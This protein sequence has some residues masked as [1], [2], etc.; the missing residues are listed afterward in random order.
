MR[1]VV[2]ALVAAVFSAA[3][4]AGSRPAVAGVPEG[5]PS[6][7]SGTT[8]DTVSGQAQGCLPGALGA[9]NLVGRAHDLAL[10]LLQRMMFLHIP[11]T[12]G[13]SVEDMIPD[14]STRKVVEGRGIRWRKSSSW[15]LPPD[16]FATTEAGRLTHV[17]ENQTV[18]SVVR[19]PRE[20]YSSEVQ[21]RVGRNRTS[22]ALPPLTDDRASRSAAMLAARGR[23]GAMETESLV[24]LQPQAWFVW[25]ETGA[26]QSGCVI[27]FEKATALLPTARMDH[28]EGRR[29]A[30]SLPSPAQSAAEAAARP[31]PPPL[32]SALYAIDTLLWAAALASPCLCYRPPALPPAYLARLGRLSH[33][34]LGAI[35][36]LLMQCA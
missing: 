13:T 14:R 3:V 6:G 21:W 20:R 9:A 35:K 30:H 26:V 24:H 34:E 1:V 27:A 19:E 25:A 32:L 29:L 36:A 31:A 18:F 17:Y 28:T 10:K 2:S 15:H 4:V 22:G 8:R 33:E 7:S 16:V 23:W 12:G 11:K 5:A